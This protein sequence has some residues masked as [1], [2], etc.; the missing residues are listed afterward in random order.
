M[1]GG[2][3]KVSSTRI[4][5]SFDDAEHIVDLPVDE[6][7]VHLHCDVLAA[8]QAVSQRA[9]AAFETTARVRLGTADFPKEEIALLKTILSIKQELH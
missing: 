4:S 3:R 9:E 2:E 1:I 7:V 5:E 6:H 8:S